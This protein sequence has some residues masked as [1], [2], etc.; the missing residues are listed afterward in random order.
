MD[1]SA[2]LP[3]ERVEILLVHVLRQSGGVVVGTGEPRIAVDDHERVDALGVRRGGHESHLRPE[4]VGD[5]AR[6]FEACGVHD[7]DQIVPSSS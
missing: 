6:T 5:E 2:P 1:A 4:S 7:R 3:F